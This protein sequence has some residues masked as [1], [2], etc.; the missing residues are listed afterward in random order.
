MRLEFNDDGTVDAYVRQSW[1]KDAV[2]CNERGRQGI[3][4]PE[5]SHIANELTA[6]GTAVHTGIA[7]ALTDNTHS[8]GHIEMLADWDR[9]LAGPINIVKH[10]NVR[11]AD[12]TLR[13]LLG[14]ALDNWHK[15]IAPEVR[16]DG[17][18]ISVESPFEF[19]FDTFRIGDM[20]VRV[21]GK[22]T[23]D[24]ITENGGWDW[25]TAARKYNQREKQEGDIQSTLYLA[26]AQSLHGLSLPSTFKFGVMFRGG[27]TQ[28]VPVHRTEAHVSWLKA[29]VRPL[30]RQAI[31]AGVDEPWVANDTSYLCN[32]T[33]C[34]WWSV[35]K[36][37]FLAPADHVDSRDAV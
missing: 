26:A 13:P 30:V 33:W 19:V 31:V 17:R 29:M 14:A 7:S 1:I 20:E 15:H 4:R 9:L 32:S 34:P 28:I 36:G 35:C 6:F 12:A 27:A 24:L 22:G 18:I 23:A 8:N 3:V 25:K 10:V 16:A 37:S 21:H 11:D 5:W 2:M